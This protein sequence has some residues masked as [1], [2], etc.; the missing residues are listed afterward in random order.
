MAAPSTGGRPRCLPL[1][2]DVSEAVS[3]SA[4]PCS[5]FGLRFQ[6]YFDYPAQWEFKT[7][8][9]RGGKKDW[10]SE[11]WD[12]VVKDAEQAFDGMAE[13]HRKLMVRRRNRLEAALAEAG[14][15]QAF[16]GQAAWRLAVG[17]GSEHPL[18]NGFTLHRVHGFPYLPGSSLKGLARAAGLVELAGEG[19]F[20]VPYTLD[21]DELEKVKKTRQKTPLERFDALATAPEPPKGEAGREER[22]RQQEAFDR[23]A[24]DCQWGRG[25][26]LDDL[27]AH[28]CLYRE[29]FGSQEARG[30][31]CFLDAYP[32]ALRTA[33]KGKENKGTAILALDLVN[34]HYGPYYANGEPPADWHSPVPSFFLTVAKGTRFRFAVYGPQGADDAVAAAARWLRAALEERG[35]G[36]KTAAGYGQF[37]FPE[38]HGSEG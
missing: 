20:P 2:K 11:V 15:V 14:P 26:S 35:A 25:A 28:A 34:P 4:A 17:L 36:A 12:E 37:L 32:V 38:A 29:A 18:E 13:A 24:S 22:R 3:S 6:M 21:P 10:K 31:A 7:P 5:N 16:T 1:P 8:D 23:L 9:G 33:T 30:K 27:R 19:D